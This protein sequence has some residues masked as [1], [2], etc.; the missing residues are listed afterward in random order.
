MTPRPGYVRPAWSTCTVA[1]EGGWT[2][3]IVDSPGRPK[4]AV[5][6]VDYRPAIPEQTRLR[7]ASGDRAPAVVLLAGAE[8]V[9]REVE[10]AEPR[11]ETLGVLVDVPHR[12]VLVGSPDLLRSTF[13]RLVFLDGRFSPHF[14]EVDDRTGY[15]GER[16]R[17]WRVW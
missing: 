1:V 15:A 9:L 7:T 2:C 8:P 4:P 14:Q 11:D 13:T 6:A 17:T 3:R 16:V 12:R 10:V 5:E